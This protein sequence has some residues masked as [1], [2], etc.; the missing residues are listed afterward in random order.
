MGD[1]MTWQLGERTEKVQ[2]KPKEAQYSFK[3]N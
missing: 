1:A 2:C 3:V